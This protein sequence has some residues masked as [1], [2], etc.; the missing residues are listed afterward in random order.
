[1]RLPRY[2]RLLLSP[3]TLDFQTAIWEMVWLVWSPRKVYRSI[4]YRQ[5][6]RSHWARDDPSFVVLMALLVV[7]S[8]LAW[9]LAYAHG[10][11]GIL[12]LI[13]YMVVVDFMAMAM[14]LSSA[15]WAAAQYLSKQPVEWA[16][17][18]DVHCNAFLVIYLYLYVLQFVLLP[19][20]Q[21]KNWIS[22]FLGNTLYFAAFVHYFVIVFMGYSILSLR[23]P[24]LFLAPIGVGAV[25]YVL[26]LFGFSVVRYML[27]E[28]LG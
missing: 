28:Y 12:K 13:L 22:M 5:Q 1:M 21:R 14:V 9:G 24:Q 17:S 8:A 11:F 26:S 4:Y 27:K 23:K 10:V 18:F 16:Y 19:V 6:N 20:L 2:L 7:A 3:P 15:E 25:G